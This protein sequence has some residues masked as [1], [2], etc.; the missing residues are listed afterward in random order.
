MT[1]TDTL[2]RRIRNYSQNYSYVIQLSNSSSRLS[3]T[4]AEWILEDPSSG[5]SLQPFAAF[6]DVWFENLYATTSNNAN[7]NLATA[8]MIGISGKCGV[9]KYSDTDFYAY[10]T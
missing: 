8:T 7:V 9:S 4:S 6:E 5:N 10:S 2:N 3:R 1:C